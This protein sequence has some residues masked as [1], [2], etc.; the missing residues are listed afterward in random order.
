M[1]GLGEIIGRG[2]ERVVRW[3]YPGILFVTLLALGKPAYFRTWWMG[4][5]DVRVFVAIVI[6]ITAS[7]VI[8]SLLRHIWNELLILLLDWQGLAA[9]SRPGRIPPRHSVGGYMNRLSWLITRRLGFS[10]EGSDPIP[11]AKQFSDYLI[12]RWAVTHAMG[13][14]FWTY[15][16]L[17]LWADDGSLLREWQYVLGPLALLSLAGN[18]TGAVLLERIERWYFQRRPSL[19]IRLLFRRSR[20]RLV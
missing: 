6:I 1:N 11:D 15:L 3:V 10:F 7:F 13:A 14:T 5:E 19:L 20:R 18:V 4:L 17:W 8:Y 2:F 12:N 9:F 16:V